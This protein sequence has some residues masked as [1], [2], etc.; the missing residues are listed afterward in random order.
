MPAKPSVQIHSDFHSRRRPN[1]RRALTGVFLCAL[2]LFVSPESHSQEVAKSSQ[3]AP[4]VDLSLQQLGEIEV[5]TASKEPEQVWHTPAAIYVI[6]QEDIR[7]SGATTI[8][9]ALRLAPGVEVAR[10][11]SD[12]WSVGIRG[13]S[14]QFSRAVLVLVDG[15]SV[16]TPLFAGVYWD[17]QNLPLDDIDRIEVIRGPGGTIWGANAF[18]GVINIIT[19]SAKDTHGTLASAATGNIEQG[20]AGVRYG[21][22]N[23]RGV[24]YRIF[25]NGFTRGA[26]FHADGN[27]FDRWRQA[28]LGFRLDRSTRGSDE[29]TLEGQ[30]YAGDDGE[31]TSLGSF[32]PPA[33]VT[34][35]GKDHVSGG[36]LQGRWKRQLS[37]S[38]DIQIQGYYDRTGRAAPQYK[39]TRDTFDVDFLHHI[40]FQA[41]QDFIW[42]FGVHVS[43][44]TFTQTV[45]T[46]DISPNQQTDRVFSGFLQDEIWLV[47]D[48][49]SLTVGTKLEHNSYSGF[50][51][52][53]SARVLWA[54]TPRQSFWAAVTRAVRTPSELDQQIDITEFLRSVPAPPIYLKVQ[55]NP[56][57]DS[58]K[59]IGYEAGFRTLVTPAVYVDISAFHNQYTG[60]L[61]YGPMTVSVQTSPF[62]YVLATLPYVNGIAGSTSGFEVAPD[63]RPAHVWEL[64]ASYSYL[65]TDLK[66]KL[67]N[68]ILSLLPTDAGSSPR[69]QIA[70]ESLINFPRNF[71]LDESFRY[72]TALPARNVPA[73]ST[74]DV[75][76]GWRPNSA[77]EIS[78][79]GQNL[80]QPRH[81]EFSTGS[82]LLIGIE[83]SAYVRITLRQ[84]SPR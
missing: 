62:P 28:R 3:A 64:R 6:T 16:Y 49:V 73:Y 55:G 48:R 69:N 39:E 21:A 76:F 59:L 50:E 41:R 71:E 18:E 34:L 36:D 75:R 4:L 81:A 79:V 61:N 9:E 83:R 33:Q 35:S 10:I 30:A 77:F 25:A 67:G 1:C 11:S 52:Q 54:R 56:S 45:P 72:V 31:Q 26:E 68:S 84:G 20:E 14:D 29:L 8:P 60:L 74:A 23:G 40:T 42:G 22:G 57:F 44:A 12:G 19:R 47:P 43:P 24:D 37:A 5:T 51:F 7:R 58:E 13:F 27:R 63:W 82:G 78:V 66:T 80:F 65:N 2:I 32:F 70:I 17:V 38:S 15:R 46:F 53:P